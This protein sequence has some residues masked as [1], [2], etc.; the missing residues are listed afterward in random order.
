MTICWVLTRA[1]C[2]KYLTYMIFLNPNHPPTELLISMLMLQEEMWSASNLTKSYTATMKQKKNL[3]STPLLLLLVGTLI[4]ISVYLKVIICYCTL[5]NGTTFSTPKA[6]P[7]CALKSIFI[8]TH[9]P[10]LFFQQPERYERISTT[11]YSKI[12][13]SPRTKGCNCQ[14]SKKNNLVELLFLWRI[15]FK[16]IITYSWQIHQKQDLLLCNKVSDTWYTTIA[17][18]DPAP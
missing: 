11:K 4:W 5:I 14:A 2:P 9:F 3:S 7:Y 6:Q 16:N 18:L 15:S 1:R 13:H 17:T 12:R 10:S 8:I